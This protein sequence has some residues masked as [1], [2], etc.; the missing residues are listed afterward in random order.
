MIKL[1]PESHIV[2]EGKEVILAYGEV[3]GHTHKV[4]TEGHAVLVEYNGN[5]YLVTDGEPALLNHEE[6]GPV[7][8]KPNTVY[9][10]G[11]QREQTLEGMW[12]QVSD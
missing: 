1:P 9:H 8:L 7:T 6:H 10:V 3:T 12:R 5:S 11:I 4:T 2:Q